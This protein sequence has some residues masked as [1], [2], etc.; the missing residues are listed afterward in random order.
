MA[1]ILWLAAEAEDQEAPRNKG[2]QPVMG[3]FGR[4]VQ[5]QIHTQGEVV[6]PSLIVSASHLHSLALALRRY[7]E[8]DR[9]CSPEVTHRR[10]RRARL[11]R[12]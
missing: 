9:V 2:I 12:G 11:R 1:A 3:H 10:R 4:D 8:V 6:R 7:R 5:H